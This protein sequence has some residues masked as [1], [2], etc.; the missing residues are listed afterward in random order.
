VP[1]TESVGM[2]GNLANI[3]AEGGESS[4]SAGEMLIRSMRSIRIDQKKKNWIKLER[5][6]EFVEA[7][8]GYKQ[9]R[10]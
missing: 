4:P 1:G 8:V 3:S 10:W 5:S 9:R 6:D 7:R 2:R